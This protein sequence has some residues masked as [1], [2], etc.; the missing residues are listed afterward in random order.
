MTGPWGRN[1]GPPPLRPRG[2]WGIL[3][4]CLA[5]ALA[6]LLVLGGGWNFDAGETYRIVI[7]V[8]IGGSLIALLG[9]RLRGQWPRGL[10]FTALWLGIVLA[11]ALFWVVR[12]DLRE[13]G[14][15]LMLA[16]M[17]G[18]A[19]WLPGTVKIPADRSGHFVVDGQVNGATVRFIVDTGASGVTIGARD[20]ERIG[21][22]LSALDYSQRAMTAGGT[23]EVAPVRLR[24]IQIG[25]IRLE[26]FPATVNPKM[27]DVSLLGMSFLGRLSGFEVQDGALILRQ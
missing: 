8:V 4:V 5:A 2:R 10:A 3:G 16:V 9:H 26:N 18:G 20:A 19:E 14:G 12:H 24:E 13:I 15:R 17:P 11:I 1:D 21:F 22:R 7:A 6:L 25:S 27:A 23:V